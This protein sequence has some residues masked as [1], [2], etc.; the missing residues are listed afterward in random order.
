MTEVNKEQSLFVITIQMSVYI[1]CTQPKKRVV[2]SRYD[3]ESSNLLACI[4]SH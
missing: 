4:L 2:A 3:N 1:N